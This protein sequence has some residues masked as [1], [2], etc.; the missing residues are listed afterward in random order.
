L[1]VP[2][3]RR[4]SRSFFALSRLERVS[5]TL[6]A[7]PLA[8]RAPPGRPAPNQEPP[9]MSHAAAGARAHH[10]SR[11]AGGLLFIALL[12][13]VGCTRGQET[14]EK[15]PVS[16]LPVSDVDPGSAKSLIKPDELASTI[17]GSGAKPLILHVGFRVLYKAGAIPGSRYVGATSTVEGLAGLKAA[18]KGQPLD[19]AIVIYCGCCP[20]DHCPNMA[21]AFDALRAL[22]Y[23]NVRALYTPHN[24]ETDWANPGYPLVKPAD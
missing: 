22:G 1:Q 9:D 16:A 18:V 24:L 13:L 2:A 10:A 21:P 17:A 8:R 6:P 11:L 23:T 14:V 7:G 3:A 15:R 19:R 20:W 4:V 12:G 5:C